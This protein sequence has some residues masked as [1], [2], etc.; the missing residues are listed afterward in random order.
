[1]ALYENHRF[2]G[3]WITA[4]EDIEKR[5]AVYFRKRFHM[6]DCPGHAVVLLSGLGIVTVLVNGKEP[7]DTVLNPG[8]TQYSRTV[9]Y[10]AFSIGELLVPGENEILIT[11][12]HG[13]YNEANG[14]WN[15]QNASWRNSPRM[16]CDLVTEDE[17]L[18]CSDLS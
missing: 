3:C 13:F 7:D 1:M 9:Y 11:L 5:A 12:G 4:D 15:W 16:I 2:R 14:V 10:R 17:T 6:D 18:L 8:Q